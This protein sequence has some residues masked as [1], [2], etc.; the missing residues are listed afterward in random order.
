MVLILQLSLEGLVLPS[1]ELLNQNESQGGE[2]TRIC[3]STNSLEDAH[4]STP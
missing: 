1:S 2:G 4:V 3:I